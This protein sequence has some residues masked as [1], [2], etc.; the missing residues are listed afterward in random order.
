MEE[1]P[2]LSPDGK[3]VAFVARANGHRHIW[4]RL[5]AGGAPLQVTRD[6]I[7]HREPRWSPDS[8]SLIYFT[9]SSESARGGTLWEVAAFGGEPRRLTAAAAGG[10]VSPDGRALAL[11]RFA[12]DGVELATVSRDGSR[13]LNVQTLG[14]NGVFSSVRWSPDGQW[15]ALQR[16]DEA[17][18]QLVLVVPSTGGDPVVVA[19]SS[20]ILGYSWLPDSSGIVYSSA[21]GSTILY[22]PTSNLHTVNRDGTGDRPL[23]FGDV[24]YTQPDIR[25][26]GELVATRT[27]IQ[28]DLWRFPL[29]GSPQENTRA[30]VRITR[31][32]GQ[33]Q[34]VSVSPD[35]TQVA[36][37]SDSGGHGNIWVSNVDGSGTRQVTF[38][39]GPDVSIGV[40]IWSST[41]DDIT[42][43]VSRSGGANGLWLVKS[44]GSSPRELVP[45][46]IGASWSGDGRWLYYNTGTG[47]DACIMKIRFPAA[48][49]PPTT[50]RCDGASAAG[51]APDGSALYFVRF[52][53]G[54]L[55]A[56]I[57]KASPEDAPPTVLAR[58]ALDRVPHHPRQLVP[59][60][61]P[62]GSALVMPL[63]DGQTT[64]LWVQPTNGG[65][66][67]PVTD[68]GDRSVLIARRVAWAP[69]GRS[70]YAAVGDIDSDI[71]LL[72]G[73]LR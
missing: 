17:F 22:P 16:L 6:L 7:D 57:N 43:I 21:S 47:G 39:Q 28:S 36:Y 26:T 18:N 2:A 44:D 32:T 38:E 41:S 72:G 66:M 24:S 69:D 40:P 8:S 52:P 46:G 45:T 67:Y 34:T 73:L 20:R 53:N 31:Q 54:V 48:V 29:G 27:Q 62:D 42:Y 30:G 33:V 58:V 59:T 3:T 49:E 71:V 25:G 64:N 60:V 61:S 56:E 10:D 4:L 51:I 35:G 70:L 55:E 23:T 14:Q 1:E 19:R 50:V 11:V 15:L 13:T 37:L 63:I 9:V 65:A 12:D 5:L 68:F